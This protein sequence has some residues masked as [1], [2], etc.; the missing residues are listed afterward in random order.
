MAAC[1]ALAI[2]FH[3]LMTRQWMAATCHTHSYGSIGNVV[4]FIVSADLISAAS[5]YLSALESR[6][7]ELKPDDTSLVVVDHS[8]D[9]LPLNSVVIADRWGDIVHLERLASDQEAWPSITGILE[10]VE[11]IR[12]KCPECPP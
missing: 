2:C 5:P 10:W 4:L 1:C 6:L 8:I 11:F 12:V 9:G 3:D 7:S